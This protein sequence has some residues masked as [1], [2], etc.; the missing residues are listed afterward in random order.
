MLPSTRAPHTL[1]DRYPAYDGYPLYIV[2]WQIGQ[3]LYFI[4]LLCVGLY[5]ILLLC[6]GLY[7]IL[8]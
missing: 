3:V 8:L 7:F 2:N 6:V 4:L 1:T 5:F